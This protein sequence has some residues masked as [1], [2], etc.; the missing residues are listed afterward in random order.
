MDNDSLALSDKEGLV[1][2]SFEVKK[3]PPS[4][5]ARSVMALVKGMRKYKKYVSVKGM[6]KDLS[7]KHPS[8]ALM[9]L[10]ADFLIDENGVIVDFL[11]AERNGDH[12]PFER[13][14]A[15]IPKDKR[16]KCNKK[17]CITNMCRE[18]YEQIR[19]DSA[20]MFSYSDE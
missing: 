1:Y 14:E 9:Q 13:I 16:C 10:P 18:N 19:R 4:G 2:A 15:F 7:G 12:I 17:D 20:A 11:R 5:F 8:R 3:A 6:V